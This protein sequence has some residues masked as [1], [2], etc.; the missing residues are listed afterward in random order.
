MAQLDK[1]AIYLRKYPS[2]DLS[3]G[4]RVNAITALVSDR[5][6][7]SAY[8]RPAGE[9]S[10]QHAQVNAAFVLNPSSHLT[11]SVRFI[12]AGCEKR[13]GKNPPSADI[14]APARCA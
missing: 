7:Q 10:V 8:N 11:A 9:P 14:G 12:A 6:W 1:S 2:L 4:V 3:V 13:T 5:R